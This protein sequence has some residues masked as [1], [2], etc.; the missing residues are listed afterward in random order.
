MAKNLSTI[1][2]TPVTTE[3]AYGLSQKNVYVF[4]VPVAANKNEI[5]AAVE[6]QYGVTVKTIKT[7]VQT[8]KA[9]RFSRGKNRYPGTTN[10][11][12]SKKAYVTLAEGSSLAIFEQPAEQT[13]EEK[14]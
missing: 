2:V 1:L 12:D 13:S 9:V 4:A 14:K 10:R 8:G 6:A 5:T 7:L 11:S 3:K